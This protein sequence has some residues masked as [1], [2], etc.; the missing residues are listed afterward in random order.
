MESDEHRLIRRRDRIA[1]GDSTADLDR[2]LRRAELMTIAPGTYI[3]GDDWRE[4][5]P[6]RRYRLRVLAAVERVSSDPVVSH[7][8]AASLWGIDVWGGWPTTVDV[9]AAPGR[10]RSSGSFRRH[11]TDAARHE[12]T[13]LGEILLTTPAQTV[14]DIATIVPFADAV[15]TADSALR[16][17]PDAGALV[18]RDELQAAAERIEGTPGSR[19]AA[20]V[21]AFASSLAESPLESFS[22]VR[23]SEEGFPPPVLQHPFVLQ[24]GAVARVDFWWPDFGVIGEA[25][26]AGKYGDDSTARVA[27][28]AEKRREDELRRTVNSFARWSYVDALSRS[29]LAYILRAAGLVSGRRRAFP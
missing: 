12:V 5:G 22:R 16:A 11:G 10:G 1:L 23:M 3:T 9:L 21:A 20:A 18:T 17:R 4:L 8:S 27:V 28:L 19:R 26:G 13:R 24:S 29:R 15:V 6:D 25:D 14:M 7:F 2:A